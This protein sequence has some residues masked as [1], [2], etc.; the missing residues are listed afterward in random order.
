MKQ[1]ASLPLTDAEWRKTFLLSALLPGV[2]LVLGLYRWNEARLR[3]A[4]VRASSIWWSSATGSCVGLVL[5]IFL[6]SFLAVI[7]AKL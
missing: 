2:G 3:K 1:E 7:L 4:Q 5:G 6:K